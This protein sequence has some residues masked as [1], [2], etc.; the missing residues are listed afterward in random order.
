MYPQHIIYGVAVPQDELRKERERGGFL[1]L[2]CDSTI[3]SNTSGDG[4]GVDEPD[5]TAKSANMPS[6]KKE[7]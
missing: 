4:G 5:N 6:L 2:E 1:L 3:D 7:T